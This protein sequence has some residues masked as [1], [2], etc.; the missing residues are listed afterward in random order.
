VFSTNGHK[1]EKL[2]QIL[3]N[4]HDLACEEVTV[5]KDFVLNKT[6]G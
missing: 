2:S 6:G 4:C 3:K 5:E 1:A